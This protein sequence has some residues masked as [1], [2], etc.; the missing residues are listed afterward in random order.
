MAGLVASPPAPTPDAIIDGDGWWPGLSIAG[1]RQAMRLQRDVTESRISEALLA[2]MVDVAAE[3]ANWK[4]VQ[5]CTGAETLEAIDA[6]AFGGE[7]RLV[8]LW[9]RAVHALA[10]ADLADTHSDISATDAGKERTEIR[11]ASADEHRRN[12]TQAIRA[13]KGRSRNRASLI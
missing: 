6:P 13:I 1:F 2:A 10:A 11:A 3:L 9:R 5:Q 7:S 12:A 8:L 4:V